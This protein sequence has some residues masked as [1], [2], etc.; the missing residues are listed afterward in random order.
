MHIGL[1]MQTQPTLHLHLRVRILLGWSHWSWCLFV[2]GVST[3]SIYSIEFSEISCKT[4]QESETALTSEPSIWSWSRSA[5]V[6]V[7]T[8]HGLEV[9]CH[10]LEVSWSWSRGAM[11]MVKNKTTFS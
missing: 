8:C 7:W 9:S 1:K 3:L 10:G 2:T 4:S 5:M 6:M 11:V